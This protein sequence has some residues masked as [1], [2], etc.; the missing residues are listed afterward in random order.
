MI[1][2]FT[3]S[4]QQITPQSPTSSPLSSCTN[5]M[6]NSFIETKLI[7]NVNFNINNLNSTNSNGSIKNSKPKIQMK[8]PF[9]PHQKFTIEDDEK[10]RDLVKKFGDSNWL[11]VADHMPGRNSR[12]CRERWL[13]YLSPTLNNS[14]FTPEEDQLLNEKVEELGTR[15][16]KIAKYFD[17]RTDQ[18][19]KNRYF[20]LKRKAERKLNKRKNSSKTSQ[21]SQNIEKPTVISQ[22]QETVSTD[23]DNFFEMANE[24]LPQDDALDQAFIEDFDQNLIFDEADMFGLFSF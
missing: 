19:V 16:V 17:R 12:Q 22:A 2:S 3:T 9:K 6:F 24:I 13:N 8:Q 15:W 5:N 21:N 20:M 14:E 4:P 1:S 11:V 18:M 7:Q 23:S 10:L